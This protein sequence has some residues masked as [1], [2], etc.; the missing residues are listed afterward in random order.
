MKKNFNKIASLVLAAALVGAMP[1]TVFAAEKD[2]KVTIDSATGSKEDISNHTF[3]AYQIFSGSQA[4]EGGALG[5]IVWGTGVDGDAILTDLKQVKDG[6]TSAYVDCTSAADVAEVLSGFG[7]DSAEARAFAAVVNKYLTTTSETLSTQSTNSLPAGYYLLQDTTTVAGEDKVA[8][9]SVLALT[10]D[11][12]VTS[13]VEKPNVEKKVGENIKYAEKGTEK[14]DRVNAEVG[15]GFNDTAD[16]TIGDTIPFEFL[17][18]VPDMS[19]YTTPYVYKFTD[20]MSDGLDFN[21]DVVVYVNDKKVAATGYAVAVK[22]ND[23]DFTVT[24]P[25][26]DAI[27]DAGDTLRVAFTGKLNKDA[28]IGSTGKPNE[29]YLEYSNSPSGEGFGKTEEDKVIVFTYEFDVNKVDKDKKPLA[30][31]GFKLFNSDKTK[32][33][34]IADGKITGFVDAAFD[35]DGKSTNGTEVTAAE[36]D[37]KYTAK[38]AGLDDGTYTLVETTTPA[39]YNTIEDKQLVISANTNNGQDSS[40]TLDNLT[41]KVDEKTTDGTL[42]TGIV[43]TDIENTQGSTLPTT[44]G[45]GTT[46]LYVAGAILVI[47]GAAVLV[48]KK[49]HEA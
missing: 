17:S 2:Y 27:S 24:I 7:N 23:N 11:I 34:V 39:G 14:D 37:G 40:L 26:L 30:G 33:A 46:I 10:N 38:F 20:T 48:I 47:A 19:A 35:T 9:V 16:Y 15:E 44:G 1:V 13:K 42:T 12:T 41:L 31:A 49:R 43:S 32:V 18:I 6:E 21:N 8:N 3:K 25:D 5:N 29:V 36:L 4:Q 28:V 22:K 45:M